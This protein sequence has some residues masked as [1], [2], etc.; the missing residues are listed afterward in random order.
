M[1]LILSR[2]ETQIS[3]SGDCE[4]CMVLASLGFTSGFSPPLSP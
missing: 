2:L 1:D 3:S 4:K